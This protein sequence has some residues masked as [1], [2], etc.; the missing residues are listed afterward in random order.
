[1]ELEVGAPGLKKVSGLVRLVVCWQV[2]WV[3]VVGMQCV[4]IVGLE[5]LASVLCTAQ[6]RSLLD[7]Q[8]SSN[9]G[10]A[11][12]PFSAQQGGRLHLRP[13]RPNL[14]LR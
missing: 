6:W 2:K 9:W 4:G 12:R 8:R 7:G 1:M 11:V 14:H 3:W 10:E 5:V 13:R